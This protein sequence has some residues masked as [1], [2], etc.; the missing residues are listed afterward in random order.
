[1]SGRVFGGAGCGRRVGLGLAIALIVAVG[2]VVRTAVAQTAQ[3][4]TGT[5]QGTMQAGKEMRMVL[6][7]AKSGGGGWEGVLYSIDSNGPSV[8]MPTSSMS[9]RGAAFSFAIASADSSFEGKLG[10]DGSLIVGMWTQGKDTHA[11]NLARANAET[12]WTIP[13]PSKVMPVDADPGWEVAAIKPHDPAVSRDNI[14]IRGRHFVIE[15]K[16][17]R[18]LVAVAYGLQAQQVQGGPGWFSSDKY[19]VDGTPDLEGQ[20][21]RRQM[22]VMVQKLLADR[23]GLVFHR[24]KKEMSVY[25]ITVPEMGHKMTQNLGNP[26]GLGSQNGSHDASGRVDRYRNVSM[27]DFAFILQLMLSKPVLDQTGLSGRFDFVLK[28]TPDD[29]KVADPEVA[30]PGIF[31][32]MQEEIGLKLEAVKA[33][34]EVLVVDKVERPS[35]N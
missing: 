18:D 10:G 2:C 17:V 12:A 33:P 8:G 5:W 20:P 31:T 14:A 21:N 28:W 7:V 23:F 1:M 35:A 15:N 11:L 13:E 4:I 29:E 26:N 34:A 9:V 30:S 32:A 22:Q 25:V 27:S 3:D 19:D 6:K 24:E 16:S